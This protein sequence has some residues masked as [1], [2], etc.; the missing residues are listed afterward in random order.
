MRRA[1]ILAA[2]LF[3]GA[4]TTGCTVEYV[5]IYES[6]QTAQAVRRDVEPDVWAHGIERRQRIAG[7]DEAQVAQR[8]GSR[9]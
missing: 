5:P 7:S 6:R 9:D 1:L 4:G 2:A 3:T 8:C